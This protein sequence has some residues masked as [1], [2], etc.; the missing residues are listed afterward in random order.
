MQNLFRLLPSVDKFLQA[1]ATHKELAW[2]SQP[3]QREKINQFLDLCRQEIRDQVITDPEELAWEKLVTRAA[4]FVCSQSRPHFRRVLNGTGVV[5][6]TNLGRS[7]LADSAV[8]A[9]SDACRYYS[10]LEFN[11]ATGKRGIRYAH[12][13]DLLCRLT[14][15]EAA[16]VVN[17]NAAAVLLILDTWAKGREAIVSRGE[18]V[19]I[20]GSFRIPEVMA[21]SG[22]ILKEVGATNR[23]HVRDYENAINE[24]TAVLMRVHTSNY[25]IIGF[26]KAVSQEEL[27]A[28]GHKHDLPVIEDMGSGNLF[29]FSAYGMMPEPTVQQ[30]VAAGLDVISFSGDKLLGGPQ[31]GIIVGRK[32]YI[33]PIKTNQLNRALRIDK[34][35]LAALEATLRLYLD[36]ELA[37]THVPTLSM[38]TADAS[39]LKAK[40]QRM[41]QRL[42]RRFSDRLDLTLVPSVSRVGGGAFPEQ[43]LATTLV[44]IK[45]RDWS[46]DELKNAFLATNPPLVGRIEDDWFCLD[47]RTLDSRHM[48][49]VIEALQEAFEGL[50]KDGLKDKEYK[51]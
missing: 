46:A 1:F 26:H 40:A 4:S 50:G 16:L 11:L 19:E 32:K 23:T 13:E 18:L 36:P 39:F 28:L 34:M 17:N 44:G 24:N 49:L 27:V 35:T 45:G 8:E 41:K 15:A 31:A 42:K 7:I 51:K 20:G 5:V 12:V 30:T 29:D 3:M 48:G 2:I 6:H 21:K 47:P 9:V 10:N 25:R 33:D 43:D 38:I 14:G 22:A 37:R